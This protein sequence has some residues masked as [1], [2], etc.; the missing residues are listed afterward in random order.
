MEPCIIQKYHTKKIGG[1]IIRTITKRKTIS[2]N[3][4]LK[5]NIPIFS[6]EKKHA[7]ARCYDNVLLSPRFTIIMSYAIKNYNKKR[8]IALPTLSVD[9][10]FPRQEAASIAVTTIVNFIR[11][12]QNMY[13]NIYF[14]IEKQSDF[15]IYK[16]LL[17]KP[18]KKIILF[19]C[20]SQ[21]KGSTLSILPPDIIWHI[22]AGDLSFNS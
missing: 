5:N 8:S 22:V 4:T 19:L 12:N 11:N 16:K 2:K 7:L 20:A 6:E 18:W 3:V 17:L 15:N 14:I 9:F 1:K 21:D 13:D 10:G